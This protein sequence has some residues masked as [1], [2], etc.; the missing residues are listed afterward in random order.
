MSK[1]NIVLIGF[2]GS[3][4][5]TLGKWIAKEHGYTFIDTD[6][7]I[8]EQ[9]QQS[10]NDIFA[11]YG[12][13][14]FR[15]LETEVIRKLADD[16]R[17]IVVSVGGGLP[18]RE[19]NRELM[20]R[21]GRVVYLDTSV[22]ELVKRL[23]GDTTRPLLAGGDM[24]QKI[25]ELMDKR[26]ALYLDAADAVVDTTGRTL[27]EIYESINDMNRKETGYGKDTCYQRTEY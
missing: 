25:T 15:D 14:H 4:K 12:E 2:M 5:T 11:Q 22:D 18:V 1:D 7:Y 8:V 19:I 26:Q 27:E 16:K 6:E 17:K 21:V 23:S 10:V 20:R 3:G 13:E 9:E 24:R